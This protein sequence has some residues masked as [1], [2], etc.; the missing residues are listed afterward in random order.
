[1]TAVTAPDLETRNRRLRRWLL[2]VV[3]ALAT[4]TVIAGILQR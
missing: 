1:M 2:A 4:A 3:A